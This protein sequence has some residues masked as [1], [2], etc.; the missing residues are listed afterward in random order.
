V[1]VGAGPTGLWLACELALAGVSTVVVERSVERSPHSRALGIHARTLEVLG[2]RGL[3][4]ELIATGRTVPS[5][6]YAL[7][8]TRLDFQHLDSPYPFLLGTPQRNV[9]ELFEKRALGLGVRVL[10]GNAVTGLT[11]DA[12]SV[13]VHLD[14]NKTITAEYVVGCDGAGSTVRKAAGIEFP[15]TDSPAWAYLG[16]VTLD[17][18]PPAIVFGTDGLLA[19]IPLG[20]NRFRVTGMDP[21]FQ[22]GPLT[23]DELRAIA[24]RIT[25]SDLGMRDP[26]WL[27]H[28]GGAS[29]VATP[30]RQERVLVAGDAAHMHFPVG[31]L[32]LNL[33]VQDAMNLGWKLAAVLRGEA[34]ESLLDTYQEE[35]HPVA[36]DVIESIR[37]QTALIISFTPETI[38]MRKVMNRMLADHPT[39]NRQLAGQLSGISLRYPGPGLVGTRAPDLGGTLFSQLHEGKPVVLRD[40]QEWPDVKA[41]V[42]RPDGYVWWASTDTTEV[43]TEFTRI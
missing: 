15:G 33:G 34:A 25:G 9:E 6:H 36:W 11:Q 31:G 16:E 17:D 7:L 8:D 13:T 32:G 39:L 12:G 40:V 42:I 24:V 2:M 3:A 19:T 29:R 35:R 21:R 14:D 10:R 22:E 1:V 38:A 43:P 37:A 30:Y 5:W 4:D 41:A 28:F 23:F 20:G 18:P 27:T 26:E